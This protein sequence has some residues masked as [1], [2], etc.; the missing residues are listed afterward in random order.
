M[1]DGEW[2]E[3]TEAATFLLLGTKIIE[4]LNSLIDYEVRS[5]LRSLLS[6]DVRHLSHNVIQKIM[7]VNLG[8]SEIKSTL[9]P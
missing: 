1:D 4:K 7:N 8:F 2:C 9:I 6:F 3:E 5:L